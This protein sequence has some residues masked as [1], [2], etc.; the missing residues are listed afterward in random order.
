VR[1]PFEIN[2]CRKTGSNGNV[3]GIG[4]AV[5]LEAGTDVSGCIFC[6]FSHDVD[7]PFELKG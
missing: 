1:I 3:A 7:A 4:E 6:G 2:A 5:I